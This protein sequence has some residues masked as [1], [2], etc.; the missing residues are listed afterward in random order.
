MIKSLSNNHKNTYN[1]HLFLTIWYNLKNQ[2]ISKV[3]QSKLSL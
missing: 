3:E 1:N 2:I